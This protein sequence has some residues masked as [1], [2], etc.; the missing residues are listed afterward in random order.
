MRGIW[1]AGAMLV[2][3]A[4]LPAQQSGV[5]FSAPANSDAVRVATFNCSLNRNQAGDLE[6]SLAGGSD[7]QARKVARI[8]RGVRPDIVLL[9]EFDYTTAPHPAVRS[10]L[11]EYLQ[12]EADW[13]REPAIVYP[14]WFTAESN[15]GQPSGRDLDH[16]GKSDGPGDALGFGR[17]PGQYGMVL[18]SRFPIREADIRT[19]RKLLW[20]DMPGNVMPVAG[21]GADVPAWYSAEDAAVM[22]LSSKSHWDVPVEIN[23][24]VVHFL[25]SHPTP[26]A[27]DGHEDR[28][29][30]RN[31]DEIRFWADYIA[32]AAQPASWIRDD[33]GVA[34]G[35]SPDALFVISGD[36][37][38]D[39]LDG[40][41]LNNA[42]RNV[43]DSPRVNQ[44]AAPASQGGVEAAEKQGGANVSHR[45]APQHDTSDFNDTSVGNLMVDHVIPS[46]AVVVDA[47]GIFWPASTEPGAELVDCSDHR[48]VWRDIRLPQP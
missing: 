33:N 43:L 44:S 35:L 1:I 30:R 31:H 10:F 5:A 24:N 18:L 6:K 32:S 22:P 12:A 37:N 4:S 16:D 26:P 7:E 29:G 23:G 19:F 48:L 34:G 21:A 39:P 17:F 28:N 9:N 25:A 38:A 20:K 8:I 42:I 46:R 15:T 45:G 14:Y 40:G 11:T 36:L 13:A 41:S 2:V 27:F 47:S 3:S